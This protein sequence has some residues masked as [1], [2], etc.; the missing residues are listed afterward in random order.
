MKNKL[1]KFIANKPTKIGELII[2][3][4]NSEKSYLLCH[5]D[6]HLQLLNSD[7]SGLKCLKSTKEID[8]FVRISKE[9]YYRPLKAE[10]N[11]SSDWFVDIPNKETLLFILHQFYPVSIGLWIA[12]LEEKLKI[13]P[14]EEKAFRQSGRYQITQ[15]AKKKEIEA[16][17]S[18]ICDKKCLKIPLWMNK[19]LPSQALKIQEIPLFCRESCTYFMSQIQKKLKK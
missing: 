3:P 14:F 18:E 4:Q 5:Y 10:K 7:F 8:E 11:L 16:M 15:K 2:L 9:N 13:C 17:V 19:S 1:A 12:Y 6:K